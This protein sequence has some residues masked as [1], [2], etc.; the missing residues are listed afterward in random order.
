MI[1]PLVLF[2]IGLALLLKGASIAVWGA[3]GLA[4]RF[5]VAPATIGLTIIAF[6][7]SLPEL[8]VT[9]EAF[10]G[11]DYGIGFGNIVGSNIANI[12][13]I[14][15]LIA[16]FQP[17]TFCNT[18][19]R[20]T[21]I[22]TSLMVLG[23]TA[24]FVLF[25]MR[26]MLDT[27]SGIVFLGVFLAILFSLWRSD[28]LVDSM[29]DEQVPYPLLL[30]GGGLAAVILGA[31]MFLTGAVEIALAFGIS[32]LVIGLSMV[33]LGTSLP[34]LA[35]S[36]VAAVK[37]STGIAMGNILGSNIF[38]LLLI[39]G[40][41]ALGRKVPIPLDWSPVVLCLFSIGIIPLLSRRSSV[42]RIAGGTLLGGYVVYIAF[43][44]LG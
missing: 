3:E 24:V 21:G 43:L 30:T 27:V 4:L 31:H 44:F 1:I 7:T 22:R 8:V 42:T 15:G 23:A 25:T 38:N 19:S 32:P 26:G 29:S 35:T 5:G 13:L 11:G 14:L 6:G 16:L 33:A 39:G 34:E 2:I 12:G 17:A 40:I 28:P 36:V 37:K 18:S 9:T 41:N 20:S 10:A